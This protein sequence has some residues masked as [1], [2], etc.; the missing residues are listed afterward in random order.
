MEK[1]TEVLRPFLGI[2]GLLW[3]GAVFLF[4]GYRLVRVTAVVVLASGGAIG[5]QYLAEVLKAPH[6][7]WGAAAGAVLLGL[8]AIPL[9][10]AEV[11]VSV[12][13]L[14]AT[15]VWVTWGAVGGKPDWQWVGAAG[16]F[17]LGAALAFVFSRFLMI[18]MTSLVGAGL[19]VWGG[20]SVVQRSI[21]Q[22][23]YWSEASVQVK[24]VALA[25]FV[26]LALV[27]MAAQYRGA[28][29]L[30]PAPQPE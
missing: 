28:K 11:V 23:E 27:G 5:G 10:R 21:V 15:V 6:P 17:V 12:G 24:M 25:A 9:L 20:A 22:R 16:G 29:A 18:A 1:V 3:V 14:T 2:V 7:L 8:A 30:K 26:L 13:A 19:V 4:L